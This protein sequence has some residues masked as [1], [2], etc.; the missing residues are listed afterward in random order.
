[1]LEPQKVALYD[2]GAE[3]YV[4]IIENLAPLKHEEHATIP[5]DRAA[6]VN[7]IDGKLQQAFQVEDFGKEVRRVAD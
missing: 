5:L 3:R 2:F 6:L 1:V 7:P 4:Q